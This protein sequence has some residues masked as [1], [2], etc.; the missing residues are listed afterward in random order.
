MIKFTLFGNPVASGA[1]GLGIGIL[2]NMREKSKEE[3]A[4]RI[5][6][7]DKIAYFIDKSE[8]DYKR[9][10]DTMTKYNNQMSEP[11]DFFPTNKVSPVEMHKCVLF[12][13]IYWSVIMSSA[14]GLESPIDSNS[15]KLLR[16]EIKKKAEDFNKILK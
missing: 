9:C 3:E 2:W 10:I 15:N 5:L 6:H 8:D 1:L 16:D 11:D 14:M 12:T 4:A 13:S 7:M